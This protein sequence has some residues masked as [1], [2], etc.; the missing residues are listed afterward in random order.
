MIL[1][2][3]KFIPDVKVFE[4]KELN[5]TSILER[6]WG[7]KIATEGGFV[8]TSFLLEQK[9]LNT[10]QSS[11]MAEMS[12]IVFIVQNPLHQHL[13]SVRIIQVSSHFTSPFGCFLLLV[14]V[15]QSIPGQQS[16]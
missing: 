5:N 16:P 2:M 4:A 15:L 9:M 7:L 13:N 10:V 1:K 11:K 14:P 6:L 12:C 3:N 8:F